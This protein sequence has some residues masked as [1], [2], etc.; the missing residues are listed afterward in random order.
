[1]GLARSREEPARSLDYTHAEIGLEIGSI[2]GEY[3]VEKEMRL[4]LDGRD[5]IAVIGTAT[6]DKSCCGA[7]GCR[8]AL[9]PGFVVEYKETVNA[10]GLPVSVVEPIDDLKIRKKIKE[11]IEQGDYV[12]Q[13]NFW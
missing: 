13:V 9:V 7:G 5:F 1:M 2:S 8:Y 6:W 3:V 4:N 10:G 11:L 12:Q